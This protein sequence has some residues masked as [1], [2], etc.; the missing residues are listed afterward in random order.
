MAEE[1]GLVK[2]RNKRSTAGNRMKALTAGVFEAEEAF[3]EVENDEDFV[4]K[5][6]MNTRYL[7][8][9]SYSCTCQLRTRLV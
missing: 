8:I 3:M 6:G 1:M 2:R 5:D 4:G 7:P 9:L